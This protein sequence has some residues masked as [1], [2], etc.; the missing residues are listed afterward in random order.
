MD[1]F[2]IFN[3]A[4]CVFHIG[5]FIYHAIKRKCIEPEPRDALIGWMALAVVGALILNFFQHELE[6]V[7]YEILNDRIN[8][9]KGTGNV[10]LG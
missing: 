5:N 3:A 2:L 10:Q 7:H 9:I 1:K 8:A 4:V 6:S